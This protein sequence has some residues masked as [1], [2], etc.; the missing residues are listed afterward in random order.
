M[1]EYFSNGKLI[2]MGEYAVLDGGTALCLPLQTGQLLVAA[3]SGDKLIHWSWTY[4]DKVLAQFTL[5]AVSLTIPGY[6]EKDPSQWAVKLI[7]QIRIEKRTFLLEGA[8][9]EFKNFFPPEWGLG[10]SSATISSL[11]RLAEADP[12]RVNKRVTG[13]SGADIAAATAG[14][15]FLY[16]N[17]PKPWTAEM[18][19][20]FQHSEN[21]LFIYSGKKQATA[22]HI[23]SISKKLPDDLIKKAGDYARQFASDTL[24]E[25]MN[26]IHHHE[27]LLA[28]A[29]GMPSRAESFPDFKGEIKSL[30]AWGGDFFMC[31]S[32]E[33]QDYMKN[34]FRTKGF[35]TLFSWNEMTKTENFNY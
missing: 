25:V 5:D 23:S 20:D 15:W 19:L 31:V 6:T 35:D 18:D 2:L 27:K 22:E 28:R 8:I 21:V 9:L 33:N 3:E 7:K 26:A 13:G 24:E 34:Y 4:G 1:D 14:K 29:L 12:F 17:Q 30:G 32:A 16:Q 10:S 11:C